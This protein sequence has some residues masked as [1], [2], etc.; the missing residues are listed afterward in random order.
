M[1]FIYPL[2]YLIADP[3]QVDIMIAEYQS[4]IMVGGLLFGL[5]AFLTYLVDFSMGKLSDLLKPYGKN[6]ESIE[7]LFTDRLEFLKHGRKV[8][9]T[10]FN[11]KWW[12]VGFIAF[13]V[14]LTSS[15][16]W[17]IALGWGLGVGTFTQL[18]VDN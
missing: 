3:N 10:I 16:N 14:A 6:K 18:L 7:M 11:I 4:T 12:V 5:I 2:C 13:V 1:M 8:F 15:K 9:L 17:K